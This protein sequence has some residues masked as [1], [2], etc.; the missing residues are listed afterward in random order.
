MEKNYKVVLYYR[1]V[2]NTVIN[3]KTD[4][5]DDV[6]DIANARFDEWNKMGLKCG[7]HEK[8]LLGIKVLDEGEI[9]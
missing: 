6:I 2:L 5:E 9:C 1:T 3:V 4:D 7:E 8:E